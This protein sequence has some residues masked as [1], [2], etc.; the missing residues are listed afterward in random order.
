MSGTSR[1]AAVTDAVTNDALM[2]ALWDSLADYYGDFTTAAAEAGLTASQ[3]KALTVLR[4]GPAA[5]RSL[6]TTLHCDASNVTGIVDRLESRGLVRREPSPTDRRVKNVLLTEEGVRA[7][8]TVR[9]GMHGTHSALDALA[10]AD[11]GALHELL[12]RLFTGPGARSGRGPG[13]VG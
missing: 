11:R 2:D 7:V 1:P 9:A 4:R 10:G 6:A 12:R 5:M 3:A 8:E 13:T